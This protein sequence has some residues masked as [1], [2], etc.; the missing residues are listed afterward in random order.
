MEWFGVGLAFFCT[1]GIGSSVNREEHRRVISQMRT[2]EFGSFYVFML[3]LCALYAGHYLQSKIKSS[4]KTSILGTSNDKTEQEESL[5]LRAYSVRSQTDVM[6][7]LVYGTLFGLSACI[8]RAGFLLSRYFGSVYGVIGVLMS[9][10]ITGCGI[11]IRTEALKRGSAVVICSTSAMATIVTVVLV[12]IICLDEVIPK[13]PLV[14]V[15]M[16]ACWIGMGV[17]VAILASSDRSNK[18]PEE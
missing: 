14:F 2:A 11:T 17:A 6:L 4:N 15:T 9:I 13:D 8:T 1:L 5:P 3:C 18:K 12:G 7:G 16:L 10:F